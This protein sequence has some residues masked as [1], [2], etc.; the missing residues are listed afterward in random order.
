MNYF[1]K[2]SREKLRDAH[3][4]GKKMYEMVDAYYWTM[5]PYATKSVIEM[6]DIIKALPFRP[7]PPTT[8]V[9]QSPYYTMRMIGP[10]GDCDDKSIALASWAK[11][12]GIPFRFIGV[13]RKKP[14]IKRI[15][16]TH[17]YTELYID[18][19]WISYDCTYSFNVFGKTLGPYD[20][21]EV[22]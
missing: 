13:G 1:M 14:G 5:A 7:D 22:L 20:R 6:Y 19:E 15:A 11:I 21:E 12:N 4:T 8:E 10:G 3:Y 2:I 18:G 16:L 9:L 17:V